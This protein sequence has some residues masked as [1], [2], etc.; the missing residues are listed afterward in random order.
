MNFLKK[1]FED[2]IGG[3]FKIKKYIF[4][5]YNQ[6]GKKIEYGISQNN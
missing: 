3:F 1:I 4:K 2:I 6:Q 5:G